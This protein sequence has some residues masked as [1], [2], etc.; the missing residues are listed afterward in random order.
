[1]KRGEEE[2]ADLCLRGCKIV[3]HHYESKRHAR[4]VREEEIGDICP[5]KRQ[6]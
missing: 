3:V 1:M 5:L 6:E 4:I 2:K